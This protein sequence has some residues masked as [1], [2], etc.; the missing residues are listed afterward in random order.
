MYIFF[1]IVEFLSIV[2]VLL[3]ENMDAKSRGQLQ[4]LLSS[5]ALLGLNKE[6]INHENITAE[7]NKFLLVKIIVYPA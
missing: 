1:K 4:A 5:T 2:N 7:I 6:P 3:W